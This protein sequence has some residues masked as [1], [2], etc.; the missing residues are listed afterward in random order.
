MTAKEAKNAD[1]RTGPIKS[2]AARPGNDTSAPGSP[3]CAAEDQTSA[4][5]PVLDRAVKAQMAKVTGGLS[6]AALAGAYLDW[7]THLAVSPGKQVQLWEK[8]IRKGLRLSGFAA[9]AAVPGQT[10]EPCIEP[11]PQD[12]RFADASWQTWPYN[13]I[14]QSFLLNQQWWHNATTGVRGV[15]KPHENVVEFATRQMLDVFS[16]SNFLLT[17]P[18]VLARTREEAGANLVRGFQAWLD[19]LRRQQGGMPPAGA[20]EFRPGHELAATPGKVVYRNHLIELI[21]YTPTTDKVRPEPVLF[22]P[23]WIMKYYILDLSPHN[24]MVKFLIAQGYTVFMVSWRNPGAEDRDL[25]MDDY[26]KM[27][28]LDAIDAVRSIT[29]DRKI[30][31]VGYCLGGTLLSIAAAALERDGQHPFASLTFFA[32]QIDF[33]EPGELQLFINESQVT[34][35]EDMMWDQGYLDTTQM[36]GAFQMIR[37]VDLIWSRMVHRYLMG[38]PPVMFDLMAW[39]ADGTRMPFRMHSEYLRKLYLNN[40]LTEGRFVVDGRPISVSDI[41]VPVFSVGTV[42]DHVAPWRSVYKMHLYLDTEL[43]FV[44][45]TGGHNTGIVSEPG[46]AGRSYQIATAKHDDRY[47][48]PETWQASAPRKDGSWWLDWVAWLDARSG[49]PVPPPPMGPALADAPGIYVLQK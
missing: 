37:S 39:N 27:G 14:H 46:H 42:K 49:A 6:P 11:L 17:N 28:V 18:Q 10:C 38:D 35:L 2:M 43:T 40:D 31:G 26:R 19:D 5:V 9:K 47:V 16:P 33:T 23:A 36:S 1:P 44:L 15:T 30:H 21:Q 4:A 22:I 29:P 25:G 13:L 45:T 3:A 32:S 7:A 34:F 8:A 12:R 41:R 48:D 20:E 24:S